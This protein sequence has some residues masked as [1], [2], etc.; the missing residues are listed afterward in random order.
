MG[1]SLIIA[2]LLL[3]LTLLGDDNYEMLQKYW[4]QNIHV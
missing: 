1:Q 2:T 4:G 3:A